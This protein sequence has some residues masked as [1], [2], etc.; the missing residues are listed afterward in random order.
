MSTKN[1]AGEWPSAWLRCS[2]TNPAEPGLRWRSL[3]RKDR[4][5]SFLCGAGAVSRMGQKRFETMRLA[6]VHDG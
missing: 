4:G 3:R 6:K 2:K 5:Y 1:G